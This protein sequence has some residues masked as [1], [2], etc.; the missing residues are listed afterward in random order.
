M[1]KMLKILISILKKVRNNLIFL[2]KD[3]EAFF[4]ARILRN[5][6]YSD[7]DI[8]FLMQ[9]Y[10]NYELAL[11][12]LK[13]LR[14]S[15]PKSRLIV[16]SD[17]DPD[18][19]YKD[20]IALF[21]AEYFEQE[22]LYT[23]ENGGR[24]LHRWLEYYMLKPSRYLIKID[25]DTRIDRRFAYL[26]IPLG[27]DIFGMLQ[28]YRNPQGGC[29][30]FTF[31][32]AKKLYDSKIFLS[33]ELKDY[34]V[35]WGKYLDR[36]ILKER[37]DLGVTSTDWVLCWACEKIGINTADFCEIHS[38][39]RHGIPNMDKKYAVVHSDRNICKHDLS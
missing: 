33:D 37:V 27:C 14:L 20:F 32:A 1:K 23:I 15:Y 10:K 31:K 17:G 3:P 8:T 11:P 26:P 2:K 5:Y 35:T 12:A 30:V 36:D 25:P 29:V 18:S 39:W 9:V 28:N 24:G 4:R 13:L 38:E 19:R 7:K 22:R 34:D 6:W 16:I 21:N